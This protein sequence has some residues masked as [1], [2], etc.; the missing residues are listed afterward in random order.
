MTSSRVYT[1]DAL[2]AI[3]GP[4]VTRYGMRGASL[5][6]SYARGS[7]DAASDIDVLVDAGE[8]F[9]AL[10]V[11]AFG[12]DLRRLT[13]KDVDVYEIRELDDGPFRDNV[14]KEAVRL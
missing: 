13:G 8:H 11:Y 6:G 5:F 7:A 14:L 3:A 12:E 9:R 10:D 1:T 2:R 4:L